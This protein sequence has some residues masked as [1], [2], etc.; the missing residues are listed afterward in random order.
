MSMPFNPQGGRPEKAKKAK[1]SA[2]G[3]LFGGGKTY[4][5]LAILAALGAAA[6]S[7]LI[8]G[9]S[10]AKE[11]YYVLNQA[12]SAR[13]QITPDMLVPVETVSG[14]APINALTPLDVTPQS[15]TDASG[16]QLGVE[17]A[18]YPLQTGDI[19]TLSNVG[20][21]ERID[22]K[23]PAE[24]VVTSFRVTPENAVA[25]KVRSGDLIDVIA[26]SQ[27]SDVAGSG[28][29][30]AKTVLHR[31]LVLDV[32]T[33]PSTIAQGAND[34]SVSNA[35][36]ANPGPES[37]AVRGGIPYLYTVA[38]TPED[39]A[40]IA[41]IRSGS[42]LIALA[43][44]SDSDAGGLNKTVSDSDVF[45]ASQVG[46]ASAGID[47]NAFG[48]PSGQVADNS[49]DLSVVEQVSPSPAVSGSSAASAGAV[50][51]SAS[52]PAAVVKP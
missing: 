5:L 15:G 14:T 46:D 38:V 20:P 12:V 52:A 27:G 2:L 28:G 23:L 48:D 32:T 3:S 19:I 31:V 25:G 33:D 9:Q 18:K 4:F 21:L 30:V 10:S 34:T 42:L 24:Y 7:F 26:V 37:A 13:T 50:V 16:E 36:S 41:L 6:V 49:G 8:M 22:A 17:F 44:N 43:S 1:S 51:P 39:A 47:L 40:K 45:G 29:S 35:T 11:T